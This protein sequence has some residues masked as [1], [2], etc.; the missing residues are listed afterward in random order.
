[1]AE[2]NIIH[3]YCIEAYNE[4]GD[5]PQICNP[6]SLHTAPNIAENTMA[7]DGVYENQIVITWDENDDT[8]TYKIYRDGIWLGINN[9][10]EIEYIDQFVD[11]GIT[12]EYCIESINVCGNSGWACDFGS[13][14]I[15]PGDV[16]DDGSIN[17]LD[18]VVMVNVILLLEDATEYIVW[19]ADLNFD[20]SI[21]VMDVVLLVNQILE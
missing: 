2:P 11:F 4:C 17:V 19:A 9:S 21:N 7:S 1:M 6:G 20:G 8:D 3:I 10:T 12:Y 15:Q 14:N 16:N 5:S 18:V 13:T